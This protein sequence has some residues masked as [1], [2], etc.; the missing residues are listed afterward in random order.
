MIGS[1]RRLAL[2]AALL[3]LVP[4]AAQA[5]DDALRDAILDYMDFATYHQGILQPQQID[6][7]LF[8]QAIFVDS[9]DASEYAQGHIP[10]AVNIDW[11][12]VPREVESLPDGMI[13]VYC[14]TGT[15]SAQAALAARLMGHDNVVMLQGGLDGWRRDGAWHPQ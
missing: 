9:R 2:A 13:V 1:V 6:Q 4:P 8:E 11:R 10:G 14:N 7:A 15:L 5:Q 3:V 12:A